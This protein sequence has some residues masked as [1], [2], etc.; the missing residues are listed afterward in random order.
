[1]VE[2]WHSSDAFH[3]IRHFHNRVTEA[4]DLQQFWLD[5]F[6]ESFPS[7]VCNHRQ[8]SLHNI[9]G[10]ILV[11][12]LQYKAFPKIFIIRFIVFCFCCFFVFFLFLYSPFVPHTPPS[13][14]MYPT[15]PFILLA[16]LFWGHLRPLSTRFI[17]RKLLIVCL[18]FSFFFCASSSPPQSISYTRDI[19]YIV[20]YTLL[21]PTNQTHHFFWATD[22]QEILL[23][24][25]LCSYSVGEILY[26]LT[27]LPLYFS[28][29]HKH[30]PCETFL[31]HSIFFIF[32][33]VFSA[34]SRSCACAVLRKY[35]SVPQGVLCWTPFGF[36][37][38]NA[39]LD[40]AISSDSN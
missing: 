30:Y 20:W 32:L 27:F 13:S 2:L 8:N 7:H 38:F 17:K 28:L 39:N 11:C 5:S 10:N 40:Q 14:T 3:V 9:A 33:F 16:I 12:R 23:L 36:N 24:F 1:M 6:S 19:S 21:R 15:L 4:K 35:S 37:R 29:F 25:A 34:N 18:L 22:F 26:L 31:A